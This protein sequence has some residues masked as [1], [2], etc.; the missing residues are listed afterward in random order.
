M[1]M[2]ALISNAQHPLVYRLLRYMI[3]S[4]T[5][6]RTLLTNKFADSTYHVLRRSEVGPVF[7]AHRSARKT[8]LIINNPNR[9]DKF[10]GSNS[11]NR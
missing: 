8:A 1:A 6:C 2:A 5:L 3:I 11:I 4:V 9:D 10:D 7:L